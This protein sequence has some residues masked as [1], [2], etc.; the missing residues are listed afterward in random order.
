MDVVDVRVPAD[1]GSGPRRL[2]DA[3][4]VDHRSERDLEETGQVGRALL[5]G[6]RD[7]VL[8]RQ[9][10]AT[11]RRVVLDVTARCL[12]VQPLACVALRDRRPLCQLRRRQRPGCGQGLIEP[13][14]VAHH[15]ER[16]VQRRPDLVDRPKD[17]LLQAI[18]ID[19]RR[20]HPL[21]P[22]FRVV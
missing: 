1:A 11:A 12:R 20:C 13:E 18:G 4:G 3:R 9:R 19:R 7:R 16:R 8:C 21:P 5:V 6:Q 22:R 14:L 10:V 2:R 17:E 15:H